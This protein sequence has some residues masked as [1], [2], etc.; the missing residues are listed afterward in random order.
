M[1]GDSLGN[2]FIHQK[3]II[4][5]KKNSTHIGGLATKH[6]TYGILSFSTSIEMVNL[7]DDAQYQST[8]IKS[9]EDIT[10]LKLIHTKK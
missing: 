8:N 1:L 4:Y 3:K 6:K 10:I 5:I 7:V 2:L 9:T